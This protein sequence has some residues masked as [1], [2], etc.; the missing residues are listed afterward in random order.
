VL[1]I[2]LALQYVVS[3]ITTFVPPVN[4]ILAA[5]KDQA[6]T[7]K[8]AAAGVMTWASTRSIVGLVLALSLP[9]TLP[10]GRPFAERDLIVV[11]AAFTIV[12][13]I[14]VQGLTLRPAVRQ[15]ELGVEDEKA[16]EKVAER[17]MREAYPIGAS[18]RSTPVNGFDAERMALLRLREDNSI[19]DEVLRKMLR[20]TDLRSRAAE[21]D[22]LPGAGHPF[23]SPVRLIA[24]WRYGAG[25]C[26]P[27]P[28][29]R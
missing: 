6:G 12:G 17:A 4:R 15:A 20:E 21:K 7:T 25:L 8:A 3:L 14:V 13:S 26:A 18:E 11:M 22:T 19:G 29:G 24:G 9:A 10:D 27:L 16:E 5:Q 23:T 28:R 1:A 2:V